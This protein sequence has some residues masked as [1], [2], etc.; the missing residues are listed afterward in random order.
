VPAPEPKPAEEQT[1][2]AAP[3]PPVDVPR[4]R[5]RPNPP[6]KMVVKAKPEPKPA[7]QRPD[8]SPKDS[9]DPDRIAALLNRQDPAS[10]GDPTPSPEPQT[11]GSIE[12]HDNAAM[13]QDEIAALKARLYQCWNPP[14][15]VREAQD[16]VVTVRISLQPDGS[17][18]GPPQ[19]QSVSQVT[20]PLAQIAAEAAL[21][22]VVQCAPFGD[23][24]RPE[25]YALWNRIEFVFDPR[26]MLGG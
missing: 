23:I 19:I 24:L 14:V 18:A 8:N 15:G 16:L 7:V 5:A 20:N 17:L 11:I 4:P 9:F 13:T 26:E 3:Q 2:A 21:R 1:A 25:K 10:G 12:G 6:P 22:A